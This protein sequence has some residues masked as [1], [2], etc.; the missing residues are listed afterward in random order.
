MLEVTM[1][2]GE[3]GFQES[4]VM[5]AGLLFADVEPEDAEVWMGFFCRMESRSRAAQ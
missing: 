2:F 4:E 1:R 5:G 3:R